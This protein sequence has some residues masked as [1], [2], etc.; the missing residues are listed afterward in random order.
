LSKKAVWLLIAILTGSVF[1]PG[2]LTLTLGTKINSNGSGQR[3]IDVAI[4]KSFAGILEESVKGTGTSS[5]KKQM[6]EGLPKGA[7]FRQF[8]RGNKIHYETVFSFDSID[9]LNQINRKLA[10][11]EKGQALSSNKIVL[12]RKDRLFFITY[13]FYENFPASRNET[14]SQVKQLVQPFTVTY[15]LW[16]PGK[17]SKANGEK[18]TE[19]RATWYINAGK[20]TEVS[21]RSYIIRWWAIIVAGA[22]ALTLIITAAAVILSRSKKSI[23]PE[24][25]P[26]ER[27][28]T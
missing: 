11:E 17:I 23:Q 7:T 8:Q 9:E 22:F 4:D 20:G 21:A 28:Q 19:N 27:S 14:T 16:L 12:D 18:I 5:L 24:A 10:Q 26:I 2:C 15:R 13:R 6:T 3:S 1:L 25:A